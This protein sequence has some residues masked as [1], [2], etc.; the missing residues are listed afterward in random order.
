MHTATNIK[1]INVEL[2]KLNPQDRTLIRKELDVDKNTNISVVI[3]PND[4][5]KPLLVGKY[6]GYFTK[7]GIPIIHPS[8]YAKVGWSTMSYR[9]STKRIIVGENWIKQNILHIN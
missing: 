8:A 5:L 1:T 6:G 9:C 2:I 4:H 3:I 7:T